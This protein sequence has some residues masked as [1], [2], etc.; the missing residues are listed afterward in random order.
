[1]IKILKIIFISFVALLL[2]AIMGLFV[3]F[4]TFD[5]D[6]FLPQITNKMS[7]IL[8]RPIT[9]DQVG[10]GLSWRGVS[11]DAGPIVVPD[12]PDFTAQA[13]IKAD[14]VRIYPDI[15]VLILQRKISI[16]Q[17]VIQ[18]P[19]IHFIRNHEGKFNVQGFYRKRLGTSVAE[20]KA[21]LGVPVSAGGESASTPINEGPASHVHIKSILI[22][23]AAISY[24]DQSQGMPLDIWL[25]GI[26]AAIAGNSF[27][28]PFR[29]SFSASLYG[30]DPNIHGNVLLYF[31]ANKHSLAISNL[32][33]H[34]DFTKLD[35]GRLN[36]ISFQLKDSPILKDITGVMQLNLVQ[37]GVTASGD[38]ET[39][40]EIRITHAVIKDFNMIKAVLSR[41]LGV[42]G[43]LDDF[44]NKLGVNDTLINKADAK[45]AYH[46]KTLFVTDATIQTN[47]FEFTAQ[48]T[49]DQALNTDMQTIL[50]VN[51]EVTAA[52][53]SRLE[54]VKILCD[55]SNR[56]T[57]GASLQGVIPRLKYKPNKDF[58]K[59]TKRFLIEEGGNILGALFGG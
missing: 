5:T 12:D 9:V 20:A 50:H 10:L 3:F 14:R 51:P 21:A 24:I 35:M 45:F 34:A 6:R 18:S 55:S 53:E 31:D 25:T 17:I 27:S 30:V 28:K 32:S 44:I 46:D 58:R 43:G 38:L 11:L 40:G 26:N 41:T 48:G 36:G 37:L 33:L 29:F 52:L 57:V 42:F 19:E 13:W 49:L 8:G 47:I 56:I 1:M 2:V 54:G 59:K 39:S 7:V 22:Q 23:D 4:Q 15:K 16:D